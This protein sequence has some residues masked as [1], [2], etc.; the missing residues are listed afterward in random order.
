M[1]K[2]RPALVAL[3]RDHLCRRRNEEPGTPVS[4][5]LEEVRT[6]DHTGTLNLLHTHIN[7]GRV[8]GDRSFPP[9]N[10]RTRLSHEVTGQRDRAGGHIPDHLLA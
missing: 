1:P 2:Y 8:E 10:K 4:H 9:L 5:L 3:Y 7:Q 6:L